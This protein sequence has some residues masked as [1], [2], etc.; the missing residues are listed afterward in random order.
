MKNEKI[1]NFVFGKQT[2]IT[3]CWEIVR[4]IFTDGKSIYGF[5]NENLPQSNQY[6][7]N[8]WNFVIRLG[9][10]KVKLIG[11]NIKRIIIYK[12]KR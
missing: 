1:A 2:A 7:V 12:L 3:Y 4:V 9:N 5:F 10:K 6:K 8:K 11:D